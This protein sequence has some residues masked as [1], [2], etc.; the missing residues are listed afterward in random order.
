[1]LNNLIVFVVVLLLSACTSLQLQKAEQ[2]VAKIAADGKTVVVTGCKELPVIEVAANV[3]VGTFYPAGASIV[4]IAE[5]D[6][7]KF[8]ANVKSIANP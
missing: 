2:V 1:M 8:C 4:T 6:V 3:A 5:K 7:E